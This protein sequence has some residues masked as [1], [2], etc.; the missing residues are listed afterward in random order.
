MPILL[1]THADERDT[2]NVRASF[3]DESATPQ[4]VT[5]TTLNWSLVNMR[6]EII[7]NRLNV[8]ITPAATVNVVLTGADLA[9]P[10]TSNEYARTRA[11]IFRGTYN[12]SLGSGLILTKEVRLI[13]DESVAV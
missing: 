2:Y 8:P 6:G 1:E 4:P 3:F 7:N 10:D 12:S 11:V 9:L 5:P 13:I